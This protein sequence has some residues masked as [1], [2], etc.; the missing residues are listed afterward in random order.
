MKKTQLTFDVLSTSFYDSF[1]KVGEFLT[2]CQE[3]AV[4]KLGLRARC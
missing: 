1:N 3:Q 4:L 2:K